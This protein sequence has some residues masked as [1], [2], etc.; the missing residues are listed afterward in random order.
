M[1]TPLLKLLESIERP[2]ILVVGD[3]VL[4]RYIW[5]NV[6]RISPEGPIPVL[7]V[8]SE[9]TR[10]GGAGNVVSNLTHLEAEVSVCGVI[11][12]DQPG[13]VLREEFERLGADTTGVAV[14]PNR[15]TPEKTRYLGFVQ[16]AQRAVQHM[17][18]VDHEN[19]GAISADTEEQL[20]AHIREVAPKQQAIV[21]S[22][23][24]KG[25]LTARV[26]AGVYDAARAGGVPVITDPKMARP[27]SAY[28][29]SSVITPN[30][31]ET[32]VATG[33]MPDD[34]KSL[35]A[36]AKLLR[37]QVDARNVVIT[38]DRDGMYV[39]GED[40]AG[41]WLPVRARD[42]YDVNGAGDMVVSVTALM[43]AGGAGIREAA[44]MANLAAGLEVS[45]LGRGT[46]ATCSS[47]ASTA[48]TPSAVSRARAG[49]SPARPSARGSSVR[50][51]WWTVW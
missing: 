3:L 33:I 30:R 13:V 11:G 1:S 9:E 27:Y 24:D 6:G 43:L 10:P 42:V 34:E 23:Y 22:D 2:R 35:A 17:L 15:T 26:L 38:L 39:A 21:V 44:M 40:E 48:T 4:D 46:R 12:E 50:S 49:R 14:R 32:K 28:R 29:G 18:R 16:S 8:T 25:L 31:Y 41:L 36:A 45:K 19:T 51:T 5:G 7:L 37:E 47:L 20:I